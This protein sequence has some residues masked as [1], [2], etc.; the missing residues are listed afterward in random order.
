MKLAYGKDGTPGVLQQQLIDGRG[1]MQP[2]NSD[3]CT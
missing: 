2:V 3:L 1:F